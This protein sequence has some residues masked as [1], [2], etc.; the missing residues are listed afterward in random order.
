MGKELTYNDT[1]QSFR[2]LSLKHGCANGTSSSTHT[3][4][5]ESHFSSVV[6]GG[7]S[8]GALRG[9][10]Q[11]VDIN[12]YQAWRIPANLRKCSFH[13][14]DK[15]ALPLLNLNSSST[16]HAFVRD[17]DSLH[18]INSASMRTLSLSPT[19]AGLYRIWRRKSV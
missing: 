14:L 9:A 6:Q 2:H 16:Q 3:L 8:N 7:F 11:A 10:A 15:P 18:L 5:A 4:A 17:G 19:Y 12:A 13:K 1:W